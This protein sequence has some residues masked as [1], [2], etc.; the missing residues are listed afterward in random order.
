M[1][2]IAWKF[3][4]NANDYIHST[5][6]IAV[7][8]GPPG[9]HKSFAS[10]QAIIVHQL[11]CGTD[12][13]IAIIRDTLKNIET[14]V[15]R[16][17][18]EYFQ[19]APDR[20]HFKD[21]FRQMTIN[22]DG[23]HKIEADLFGVNDPGDL[24]RLQGASS[25]ALIWINDPA[26]MIGSANAGVPVWAFE[27]AAYRST[28]K[29]NVPSRL[30]IDMN[31]AEET[32]WTSRRLLDAPAVNPKYPLIRKEVFHTNY[33][34]VQARNLEAEQMAGYIF[35]NEGDRARY[36][37]GRP[38]EFKPG[39]NVTPAYKRS[40]HLCPSEIVPADGLRGFAFFDGW[41]NPAC[42]LGQITKSNRLIFIDTLF[43]EGADV[44][45][46]MDL[47][48]GPLLRD[49]KWK[50]K[51][52]S[53][54]IGGDWSMAIGDQGRMMHSAAKDVEKFFGQFERGFKPRFEPG[55][56]PWAWREHAANSWLIKNNEDNEPMI[57]LSATNR[58][59]D[60]GLNG[61]WHFKVDN[62][63]DRA[64]T[65]PI[66]DD[67]SHVCE[68]WVNAVYVLLGKVDRKQVNL[69]AMFRQR[70]KQLNRIKGYAVQGGARRV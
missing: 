19:K 58:L 25:W 49:P 61:A 2:E 21:Q 12:I 63:G 22:L 4:Q 14:S 17:F 16:S 43:M 7:L 31:Y 35:E 66:N 55:P 40:I 20:V 28:R 34:E 10:I 38:A 67:I 3:G 32:H 57:Y 50:D 5:A 64:S 69:V 56:K 23:G 29:S 18:Q 46:L 53:W 60:R 11:R 26:P 54:R 41:H 30:Q 36:V 45:T 62:S 13:N 6:Q 48:V 51:C 9:T 39:K 27:H 42:V 8:A 1:P 70:Q 24:Q 68:A 44:Q 65:E 15:V 33:N 59:L 37:D 47:R 52:S